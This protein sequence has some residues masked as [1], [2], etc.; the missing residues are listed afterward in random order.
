MTQTPGSTKWEELMAVTSRYSA[1]FIATALLYFEHLRMKDILLSTQFD[2]LIDQEVEQNQYLSIKTRSSRKR[3]IQEIKKRYAVAPNDFWPFFFQ[4]NEAEQKIAL[5]FLCLKTYPLMM[6]FQVEVVL[7]KWREM[8]RQI[9]TIDLQM[10]L[11]EIA[12][13]HPEVDEWTEATKTKAITVYIRTLT[14]AGLLKKGQLLAPTGIESDFWTYFIQ[15]GE[16]WLLNVC[17]SEMS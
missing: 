14:E 9:E 16:S 8:S 12:S 15:N 1:S 11:D 2:A 6:D 10:R 13:N 4:R 5:L 17:F 3:T 7:K